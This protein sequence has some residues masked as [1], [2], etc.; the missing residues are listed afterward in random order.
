MKNGS[1]LSGIAGG[2]CFAV[3]YVLFG[4][5]LGPSAIPV[6]ILTGMLGFGA[7]TLVFSEDKQPE[8][9][10]DMRHENIEEILAKAKKMNVEIMVMVNKVED[11]DLQD[12]ISEI[13]RTTNKIIDAVSKNPKKMKYVETF[14]SYYLPETLK[15]LRKIR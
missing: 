8:L 3:P 4:A 10:F 1:I 2:V 12:D 11:S 13:Y 5:A 7:G 9:T 14:F 6:S 15:L